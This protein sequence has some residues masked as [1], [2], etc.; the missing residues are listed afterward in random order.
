MMH[1]WEEDGSSWPKRITIGRKTLSIESEGKK[2]IIDL[3]NQVVSQEVASDS[4]SEMG[5]DGE[6]EPNEEGVLRLGNCSED[7]TSSIN[8]LFHW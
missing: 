4:W 1:S 6:M 2:Y 8:G 7:E 3:Q 5:E